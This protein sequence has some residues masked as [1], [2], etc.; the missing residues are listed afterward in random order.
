M[1]N[2]TKYKQEIDE[3]LSKYPELNEN[4]ISQLIQNYKIYCD[5]D[6]ILVDLITPWLKDIN[7]RNGTLFNREDVDSFHWFDNQKNGLEFLNNDDVYDSVLPR[8]EALLF[9]EK[10][11]ELGLLKNLVIVTATNSRN[12]FSKDK[13]IEKHFKE[14]FSHHQVVTTKSKDLLDYSN[15]V[16]I[17][18]GIHNVEAVVMK[19]PYARALILH[20]KHNESLDTGN[21]IQ[22]INSLMDFFDLLPLLVLQSYDRFFDPEKSYLRKEAFFKKVS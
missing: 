8:Q 22:R 13:H 16:L 21:R 19:N 5:F 4:S 6:E 1:F 9:L 20:Y 17:D 11:K 2:L 3:I 18:D 12:V 14:Y 7:H 15:A 10:L